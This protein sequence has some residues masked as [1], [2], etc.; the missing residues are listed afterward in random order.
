M[1]ST[2]KC[3]AEPRANLRQF[4]PAQVGG[5]Q[6]H[7]AMIEPRRGLHF[8]LG[9]TLSFASGDA[10]LDLTLQLPPGQWLALQGCSGAGKTT[11]LRLL[12]GLETA[13][14]GFIHLDGETWFDAADGTQLATRHRRVGLMF[15]EHALFP[16]M[17]AQRQIDFAR[18]PDDRAPS[19]T[20]LL[21]LVG[22]EKLAARLPGELS[23]GQRQRLALARTLAS[24]PRLLL[25]DEP[26]SALDPALRL[27]MQQLLQTV[28]DSGLVDYAILVTHDPGEADRLTDRIVHL[29]RGQLIGDSTAPVFSP[30]RTKEPSCA[31]S[32]ACC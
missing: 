15:Q 2:P 28:R 29:Q 27:S 32:V 17:S 6:A 21:E 7:A 16:H 31:T 4:D 9:K 3:P 26:L 19:T 20:R 24:S 8:R 25:L 30:P 10:R 14:C 5:K 23:G 12:A 13:D 11:V 22:L 18:R 1:P